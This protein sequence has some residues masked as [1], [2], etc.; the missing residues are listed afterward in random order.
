MRKIGKVFAVT[1]LVAAAGLV[2]AGCSSGGTQANENMVA[3][4]VNG[5]N[6]MLQ[7]V[8]REVNRQAG[9]N[10]SARLGDSSHLADARNRIGHELHDQF[11]Q[12][13]IEAVIVEREI[14]DVSHVKR[15]ASLRATDTPFRGANQRRIDVDSRELD[16]LE[17]LAQHPK[18]DAAP[19]S[20]LQYSAAPRQTQCTQHQRNLD[21]FLEAVSGFHV[22]E[23]T[24]FIPRRSRRARFVMARRRNW[25]V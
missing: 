5:H 3:A 4:T 11:G 18:R 17:A 13:E 23:R 2:L 6:I 7:E 21:A 1:C 16:W 9:G 25:L 12:R 15:Y 8:E 10:P 20:N 14:A 22:S 24:V 19:A